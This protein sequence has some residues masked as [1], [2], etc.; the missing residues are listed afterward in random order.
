MEAVLENKK[1]IKTVKVLAWL[2]FI[3]VILSTGA[4][5]YAG[6]KNGLFSLLF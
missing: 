5:V 6:I 4:M 2:I 3:I 1:S